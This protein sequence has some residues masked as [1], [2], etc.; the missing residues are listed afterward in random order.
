VLPD[1]D[2]SSGIGEK[3]ASVRTLWVTR[4]H[5]RTEITLVS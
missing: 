1:D 4:S 3:I 5:W 2:V